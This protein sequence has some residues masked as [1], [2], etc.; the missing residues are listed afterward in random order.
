[1]IYHLNF[2]GYLL[3]TL[4]NFFNVSYLIKNNY[5]FCLRL[6]R[7]ANDLY[8]HLMSLITNLQSYVFVDVILSETDGFWAIIKE[9][10]SFDE[11]LMAHSKFL[12]NIVMR[13][14]LLTDK[15][16]NVSNFLVYL[17]QPCDL[18]IQQCYLF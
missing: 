18:L 9:S 14:F 8:F 16:F 17:T 15:Q 7:S 4:V 5:N 1:M 3:N 10:D 11:I 12:S 2:T 6:K 13:L